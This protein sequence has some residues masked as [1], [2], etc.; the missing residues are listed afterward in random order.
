MKQV[1]I[2][3]DNNFKYFSCK[4][5]LLGNTAADGTSGILKNTTIAVP[6][7]YLS[8]FWRSL[9]TPLIN[10]K[11]E[12]KLK[13]A[14]HCVLAA[15]GNDNTNVNPNSIIFT[16]KDTTQY[17]PV[18]TLSTKDNQKLSKPLSKVF[19]RSVYCSEYKTK[20]ENKGTI[21]EYKYFLESNTVGAD[22]LFVLVYSNQD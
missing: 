20:T 4:A 21:N 8:N 18:V 7:K 2:A 10:C 12:L 16:I 5:K 17:V 3:D 1:L 13:W 6:I 11:V 22:R 19:E 14:N 15:N 9:E